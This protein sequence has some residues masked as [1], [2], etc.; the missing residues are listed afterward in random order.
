MDVDDTLNTTTESSP[1]RTTPSASTSP[2]QPPP[3]AQST[4]TQA[5]PQPTAEQFIHLMNTGA[6]FGQFPR[7][8]IRPR[9]KFLK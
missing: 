5:G 7:E 6:H 1:H 9:S 3:T 8:I 2:T 4:Q